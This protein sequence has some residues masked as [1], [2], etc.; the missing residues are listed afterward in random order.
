[1]NHDLRLLETVKD[2]YT[3]WALD[4]T[5]RVPLGYRFF[6]E[7][8]GGG[9]AR[10]EVCTFLAASG[11]GKTNFALNVAHNNPD[12]GTV[13]FSLEMAARFLLARLACIHSGISTRQL[14][15]QSLINGGKHEALD[16]VVEYLPKLAIVDKPAM[17][18]KDMMA[19]V[20][21]A[22]DALEGERPKLVIIDYLEL[23][24]GVAALDAGQSVDKVAR[25]LK[26]FARETDTAVVCLHQVNKGEGAFDGY[27]PL[28]MGSARFGGSTQADFIVG[29]Y[30]PMKNPA[31]D[32]HQRKSVES[33]FFMQLIKNRAGQEQPVGKRHRFDV[34]CLKLSE[35]DATPWKKTEVA[36]VPLFADPDDYGRYDWER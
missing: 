19:S 20:N 6:D 9:I 14:E 3:S 17:S 34:E 2:E 23:I 13:F 7:P 16:K 10:G 33:D 15:A 31:L 1:M 4:P 35:W 25:K 21:R 26:D 32:Q 12:V 5:P 24:S 18:L 22:V 27:Q 30:R 8:T 11:V 29:A 28:T 36:E